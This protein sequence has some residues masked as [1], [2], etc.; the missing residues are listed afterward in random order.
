MFVYLLYFSH[1]E[2]HGRVL[3]DIQMSSASAVKEEQKSPPPCEVLKASTTPTRVT[4]TN[5]P[6]RRDVKLEDIFHVPTFSTESVFGE[7]TDDMEQDYYFPKGVKKSKFQYCHIF[8]KG[9]FWLFLYPLV[10][11]QACS[12]RD[13]LFQNIF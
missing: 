6:K 7:K 2:Q 9:Y 12:T 8:C 13:K 3:A 4:R 5:R 1:V 10:L 11:K